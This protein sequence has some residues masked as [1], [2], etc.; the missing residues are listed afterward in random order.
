MI[1]TDEGALICDL[2]E[3]Y[4]IYDYKS[5]PV[6]MVATLSVGLREDSRIKMKINGAKVPSNTLILSIIADGVRNLMWLF[7]EDGRKGTNRP[8]QL[9][10]ILYG[11]A[12]PKSDI[13]TFE[14]PEDYEE[15]RQK[16]LQKGGQ[17]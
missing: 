8:T 17:Q 15:A 13:V 11:E 5:L 3:T 9:L 14:S 10:E 4:H 1:A 12:E 16:I 6:S 2:A 7:S